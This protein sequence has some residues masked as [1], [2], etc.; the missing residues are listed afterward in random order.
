MGDRSRNARGFFGQAEPYEGEIKNL[1]GGE[2]ND[3]A[4]YARSYLEDLPH[5]VLADLDQNGIPFGM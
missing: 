3:R 4:A 2:I 1:L 5:E